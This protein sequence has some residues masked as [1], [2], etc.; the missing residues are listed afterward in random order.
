MG[1]MIAEP[2]GAVVPEIPLPNAPLVFVVAQARFERL[3]SIASE[4]FIAGFQEAI[5][6]AYPRMRR[7]QQA[8][9]L[10]GPDG[11]VVTSEAGV[12]PLP[13]PSRVKGAAHRC[14]TAFGRP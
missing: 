9:V 1:T 5:R 4:G 12:G 7:E 6:S 2:F 13:G 10:I 14:A 11:R 8:S 3:A